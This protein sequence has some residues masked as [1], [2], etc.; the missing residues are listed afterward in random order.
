M[1]R[2]WNHTIA[3]TPSGPNRSIYR[4]VIDIDAGH[5]TVLVWAWTSLV[6]PASPEALAGDWLRLYDDQKGRE[7]ADKP[8]PR[9]D[10]SDRVLETAGVLGHAFH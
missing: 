10:K 5:L 3:I 8:P 4:D 7:A 2:S 1:V 6:L 9:L